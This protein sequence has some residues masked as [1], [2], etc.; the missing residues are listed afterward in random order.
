[1]LKFVFYNS[2]S[3]RTSGEHFIF[4]MNFDWSTV[5]LPWCVT[6]CSTAKWIS[7]TCA[8]MLSSLDFLLVQVTTGRWVDFLCSDS[9]RASLVAQMV[10][11][12]PARQETRVWTLGWEGL[13][14]REWQP[15]PV[16]LPGEYFKRIRDMIFLKYIYIYIFFFLLF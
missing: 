7:Y 12:R 8:Y 3:D 11:H 16:F 5:A 1:M 9:L 10:K 14:R 6:F 2:H 4:S 15:I 13:W